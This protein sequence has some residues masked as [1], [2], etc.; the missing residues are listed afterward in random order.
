[1]P[2]SAV[3]VQ[4]GDNPSLSPMGTIDKGYTDCYHP[5]LHRYEIRDDGE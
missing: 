2:V 4:A 5:T 1:M 3:K